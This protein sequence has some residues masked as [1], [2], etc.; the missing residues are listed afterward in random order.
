MMCQEK[1]AE[2]V[3][4]PNSISFLAK[5]CGST[6]GVP[7]EDSIFRCVCTY[8]FVLCSYIQTTFFTEANEEEH[9]VFTDYSLMQRRNSVSFR[10]M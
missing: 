3:K 6:V 1:L 4:L 10:P 8:S 9:M 2:A 7:L 5:H